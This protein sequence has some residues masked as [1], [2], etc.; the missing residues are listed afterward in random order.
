[1]ETTGLKNG[2]IEIDDRSKIIL[3]CLLLTIAVFAVYWQVVGFD[4]VNFDDPY[5]VKD[6]DVVGKG[7]TL[8]GIRWAFTSV[9]VSN[10]HPLTWISHMLDVQF[11]GMSP[12]FHQ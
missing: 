1:M 10:W 7:I 6:N 2:S 8:D 5:Y 9:Y 4:F 12:G 11:F 3:I